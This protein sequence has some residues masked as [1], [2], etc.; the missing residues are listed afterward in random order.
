MLS[1]LTVNIS[2]FV[3][4]RQTEQIFCRDYLA[5][6]KQ[7]R[8]FEQ[9]LNIRQDA[10]NLLTLNPSPP[11]RFQLLPLATVASSGVKSPSAGGGSSRT[12]RRDERTAS[13]SLDVKKTATARKRSRSPV[14]A[15]AASFFG[16]MG[17]SWFG[18]AS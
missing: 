8:S 5:R 7:R 18:A 10:S 11:T 14:A 13:A 3:V 4:S 6:K 15:T 9:S 1:K 16:S 12:P 17:S 2:T